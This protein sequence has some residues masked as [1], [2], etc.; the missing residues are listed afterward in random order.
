MFEVRFHGRGGQ[1][2]VMAAQALASAAFREDKY[3]VAF[4]FFGAERRGAPVLAFARVH[5]T[6]IYE[7]TQVYTPDYVVVL[8][9]KLPQLVDVT[10]GLKEGGMV[11]LN[12]REQPDE[13]ELPTAVRCGAVDATGVALEVF[14]QPITNSAILGAFA[15]ATGE[16]SI[17]AVE[18]GIRDIFGPRIGEKKAEKNAEA[19]RV[20]YERTEAGTCK[21]GKALDASKKWLPDVHDQPMGLATR[22]TETEA[23]LV[24]IGS[25]CENKTGSWRTFKPEYDAD[26][27]IMCQQCWF[28]C[29]DAAIKRNDE[30]S[31]VSWDF[32]YCKGCGICASVCPVDAIKMERE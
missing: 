3:A 10:A 12:T 26:K 17:E 20:A 9:D 28:Y 4:P 18:Q 23:G 2:A 16:L 6:K 19:A 22:K 5:D 8:D 30:R 27:C 29:P 24:G 32:D 14:G 25:F 21:A 7:K 31:L 11:I 15:K 13:V 1:G